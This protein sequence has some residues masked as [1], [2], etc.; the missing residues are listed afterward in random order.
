MRLLP[1]YELEKFYLLRRLELIDLLQDLA[2]QEF[3]KED[4]DEVMTPD[5]HKLTMLKKYYSSVLNPC[6]VAETLKKIYPPE[7]YAPKKD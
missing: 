3:Y 4:P 7:Q 2:E 6:D 1:E 5:D